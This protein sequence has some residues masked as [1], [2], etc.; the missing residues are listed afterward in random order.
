MRH[1]EVVTPLRMGGRKKPV[2]PGAIVEL[3]EDEGDELMRIG[4]LRPARLAP[5]PVIVGKVDEEFAPPAGE[6][7]QSRQDGVTGEVSGNPPAP[8]VSPAPV[9]VAPA[10]DAD[11]GAPSADVSG[12]ALPAEAPPRADSLAVIS[13]AESAFAAEPA[14]QSATKARGRKA[15]S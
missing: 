9:D 15:T 2:P 6:T 7:I 11:E 13:Q 8:E 1:Y 14:P 5:A 12:A 4:A 10:P 3:D